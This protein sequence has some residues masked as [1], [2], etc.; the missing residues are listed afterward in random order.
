M[1]LLQIKQFTVEGNSSSNLIS[2]NTNN[3][4]T[5]GNEKLRY[6]KGPEEVCF[7][8]SLKKQLLIQFYN[9]TISSVW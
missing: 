1:M 3:N 5:K 9:I 2:A 7:F 8:K 6:F 4:R